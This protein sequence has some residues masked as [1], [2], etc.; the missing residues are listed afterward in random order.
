MSKHDNDPEI[1]QEG[2]DSFTLEDILQEFE[3]NKE[4]NP[5]Q[6]T[7]RFDTGAVRAA[8][9]SGQGAPVRPPKA[10]PIEDF[11]GDDEAPAPVDEYAS[12][13]RIP[14]AEVEKALAEEAEASAE[15][16]QAP[17]E[18]AAEPAPKAASAAPKPPKAKKAPKP[19]K[20]EPP[21]Q[22]SPDKMAMRAAKGL[23]TAYV[24]LGFAAFFALASAALTILSALNIV[25]LGEEG[26]LLPFLQCGLM[27]LCGLMAFDVV[28]EGLLRLFRLRLDSY[29]LLA[30]GYI[31]TLVDGAFSVI[32]G[33]GSY[34]AVSC[35]AL[36][37]GLWG[38]CMER[39]DLLRAMKVLRH[40]STSHGLRREKQFLNGQDGLLTGAGD[41][42]DYL[43]KSKNDGVCQTIIRVYSVLVL[44]GSLVLAL[45]ITKGDRRFLQYWTALLMAGSPVLLPVVLRR[46][47]SRLGKRLDGAAVISGWDGIQSLS[48]KYVVPISDRELCPADQ[49]QMNGVKFYGNHTPDHVISCATAVINASGS[50]L[51]NIFE[52]LRAS[53]GAR[54]YRAEDLHQYEGGLSA[55]VGVDAVVLGTP[56][57]LKSMGVELPPEAK[58]SQAVYV[59]LNSELCGVFALSFGKTRGLGEALAALVHTRGVTPV[60]TT[61]DF[62]LT[63]DFLQGKFK[64]PSGKL[65]YPNQAQRT[66][67]AQR[68]PGENAPQCALL[69]KE[70]LVT[71]TRVVI[72]SRSLRA[73]VWVCTILALFSGLLGLGMVG[74]V[75]YMG[76]TEV[77]S[78]VNVLLYALVWAVPT[79]LFGGWASGI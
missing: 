7:I 66:E 34:S 29:A 57:F 38:L 5:E 60:I 37:A 13:I 27:L 75:A 70:D 45:V 36:C 6:D 54:N 18:P 61:Q 67:L 55:Q 43:D 32:Q 42:N 19:K 2:E 15:E 78:G 11:L 59:A 47:W 49:L 10:A 58:V 41:A 71:V 63:E 76:A 25:R 35:L 12:T 22:E 46:P 30:F 62:I 1:F 64:V 31:L 53:R 3:Q 20:P 21:V 28:A 51:A 74:L 39:Q 48:G 8:V 77:L 52:A 73:S 14:A 9:S 65:I 24:R 50:V 33:R 79:W 69:V 23:T 4:P 68:A 16:P 44:I 56:N 17:E 40:S 72:G 26:T